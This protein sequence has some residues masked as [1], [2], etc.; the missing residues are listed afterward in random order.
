M[1]TINVNDKNEKILI[2][3]LQ[4]INEPIAP[5]SLQLKPAKNLAANAQPPNLP[6]KAV[7]MIAMVYAQVIPNQ[8][9]SNQA[10]AYK[11]VEKYFPLFN[12]PRLVERPERVKYCKTRISKKKNHTWLR[13]THERKKDNRNHIF[14]LFRHGNRKATFTWHNE[15]S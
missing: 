2:Y 9:I 7:N 13:A 14:Q 5:D 12:K 6:T 15:T 4:L 8:S 3:P 11:K 1:K 10:L